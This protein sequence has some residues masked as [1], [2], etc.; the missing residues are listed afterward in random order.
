MSKGIYK[1]GIIHRNP[2]SEATKRKISLAHR[3]KKKPWVK[4]NPQIFKKGHKPIA[5]FK[6][7]HKLWLGKKRSIED[8]L[9]MSFA[10]LGKFY[11][12]KHWNW[13]G[14]ISKNNRIFFYKIRHSSKYRQWRL[15]IFNRDNFTC[16]LC[17][18]RGG[19][20]EADHQQKQFSQII[21]EYNIKNLKKAMFCKELWNLNNGRTLCISCHRKTYTGV[22]KKLWLKS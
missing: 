21:H 6:K 3:G 5:G 16:V 1:R 10:K 9:K 20:L 2:H 15:N 7:G 8:R 18:K 22:S 13:K 17:G 19:W 12:E 4:N 14:G 11:G